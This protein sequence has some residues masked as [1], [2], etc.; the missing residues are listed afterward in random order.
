M[1]LSMAWSIFILYGI[2][3]FLYW[4]QF[5]T[6]K[7]GETYKTPHYWLVASVILHLAF[8]IS[9]IMDVSR[10]PIATVS[11][12]IQTFVLITATLYLFLEFH[13][14]EHSQGVLI[15]S[16][17]VILLFISN[18]S[19]DISDAINPILYDVRFE[20]HVL[21]ML[22]A[23]SGFMIAFI[24]SVLHL[25]LSNEI[26][27]K[28]PG[29]FFRRLP[30]LLYFERIS[31][32][33]INIGLIFLSIGFVLG[34]YSA[35]KVWHERLITDPKIVS[36]LV[37]LIIYFVYF[38]GRKLGKISGRRAAII[39]II[40]FISILISY[41]VISKLIPGEHQFG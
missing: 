25:L 40:G 36:V 7:R 41:L 26:K 13:L 5:I 21:S 20:T 35:T 3:S 14:K 1:L 15:L 29:I 12:S 23:N 27:K 16:L 28:E 34:F 6:E 38:L 31:D 4:K 8:I 32:Y 30:S 11:E 2:T 22:L 9:F 37:T 18:I 19:F 33:A 39:S 10:I 17:L 24:A